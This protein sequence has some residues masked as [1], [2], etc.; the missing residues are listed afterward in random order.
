MNFETGRR[1]GNGAKDATVAQEEEF[2]DTSGA[3]TVVLKL[4][5]RRQKVWRDP[6]WVAALSS[7]LSTEIAPPPTAF[8]F[9]SFLLSTK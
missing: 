6:W 9:L 2:R 1:D 4:I 8:T 5:M 7:L 3:A